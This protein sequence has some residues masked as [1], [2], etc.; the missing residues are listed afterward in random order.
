MPW[1]SNIPEQSKAQYNNWRTHHAVLGCGKLLKKEQTHQV[2][3]HIKGTILFY[4]LHG[5][6]SVFVFGYVVFLLKFH[7]YYAS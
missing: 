7:C 2:Q 6:V 4:S 5:I 1:A 3:Q